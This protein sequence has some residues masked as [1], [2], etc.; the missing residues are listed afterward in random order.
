M[1]WGKWWRSEKEKKGNGKKTKK[2]TKTKLGTTFEIRER[3]RAHLFILKTFQMTFNIYLSKIY[4]FDTYVFGIF[5][6]HTQK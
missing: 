6:T 1:K 5:H 3:E 2:T 4:L